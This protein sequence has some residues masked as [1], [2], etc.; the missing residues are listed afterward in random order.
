LTF[1]DKRCNLGERVS[2]LV[3]ELLRDVRRD[4]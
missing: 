4:Q 3:N 1:D 2:C